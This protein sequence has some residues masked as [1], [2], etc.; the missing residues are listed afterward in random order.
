MRSIWTF[1]VTESCSET[2][3]DSKGE[4]LDRAFKNKKK[5][6]ALQATFLSTLT[7]LPEFIISKLFVYVYPCCM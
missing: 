1:K 5:T 3:S 6:P 4:P 2:K 7:T